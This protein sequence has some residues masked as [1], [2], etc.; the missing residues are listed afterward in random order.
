LETPPQAPSQASGEK[1]KKKSEGP[2]KPRKQSEKKTVVKK[3][4]VRKMRPDHS[5]LLNCPLCAESAFSHAE[6]LS[7]P[8]KGKYH[9][10]P[11]LGASNADHFFV[12][13]SPMPLNGPINSGNHSY[14]D[15]HEERLASGII[16]R[17]RLK[18][19]GA[20]TY[21]GCGTYAVR[22]GKA[23]P[24]A[25]V[26]GQCK[27]I[28][29]AEIL[30]KAKPNHAI[31]IFALG[32]EVLNALGIKVKKLKDVQ[33]KFMEI[34]IGERQAFVFSSF[35]IAQLVAKSG[36]IELLEQHAE[37]F[38]RAM[39]ND[40]EKGV[41]PTAG[42]ALPISQLATKYRIPK[43]LAEAVEII[44]EAIEYRTEDG[45]AP[46][47][48]LDTE[49]NTLHPH[50]AKLK[51][52][53]VVFSW[54]KG[55]AASIPVEHAESPWTL[56]D[57]FPYLNELLSCNKPKIL[58]HAKFDLRVLT[59][60]GFTV[61]NLYWD[62]LIGEHL[63]AEDKTGYYGL[64]A[65]TTTYLPKYAGY[66]DELK[67]I[68][69]AHKLI[70]DDAPDKDNGYAHIPLKDLNLYGACDAD[71]TRQLAFLQV[72][73]MVEEN[74][75]LDATC[76]QYRNH[77]AESIRA[78]YARG[79]RYAHPLENLMSSLAMPLTQVLARME[80]HGF[81]VDR[82]HAKTLA[83]DMDVGIA[84]T[85]NRLLKMVPEHIFEDFNF[86]SGPQLRQLLFTIGYKHP[87]S[88]ELVKYDYLPE[89]QLE[90][91]EGGDV[92]VNAK[93]LKMLRSQGCPFAAALLDYRALFKART[94]FIENI[95]NLSEEDGRMH[96]TF[97]ITGTATGR[98]SSSHENMQ[99][100]PYKIEA[101]GKEYH[102]KKMFVPTSPGMVICN[103]DAKAAEVR[104]YAAY[105]G[106]AN[107]IKALKG[108]MDPHSFF[109]SVVYNRESI[110]QNMPEELH[111]DT[112]ATIGID[113]V[114][115]W[116]YED[117]QNRKSFK[118]TDPTYAKKLDALRTSIKKVVFGI[119]YGA[120][121]AKISSLVGIPDEQAQAIIQVLF[122][123]F[124]TIPKY[125]D[126]VKQQ[127]N[128]IGVLETL[129][130]RRRHF[131]LKGV[132]GKL[133]A[134]AER[135]GVNFKIQS[136][137]SDIVLDTLCAID[138][139]I[140]ALGGQLLI[141]VHDSLVFQIPKENL[142]KVPDLVQRYCVDRVAEKYPWLPVPF[143]WD[144]SAGP[145]YGE[146]SDIEAEAPVEGEDLEDLETRNALEAL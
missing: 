24:G 43:T 110:L 117:F 89:E 133:R 100:I 82:E 7:C 129:T 79:S 18:V 137:S 123:M 98:L 139:P 1:K 138:A 17:A 61:S 67:V 144:V 118:E 83:K 125:I 47:I 84:Q 2:K 63:L 136:S 91:T 21:N 96:T 126:N 41:S 106:D 80:S 130:G 27:S 22:C 107:L 48:S 105:S 77:S 35:S 95:L 52:L 38:F 9:Y 32:V 8:A 75:E 128:K 66:E 13:A 121:P 50:K 141:T 10:A 51:L 134:R 33:G 69:N 45:V 58:H 112:L 72:K 57:I 104:L 90:H 124:P 103:A 53:T 31:Y 94:T 120:S 88:G 20:A 119:L 54:K 71:V 146:Q 23:D 56:E 140:R 116:S 74:K 25:D 70:T 92:S 145:S 102:I 36:F 68:D 62:T 73:R 26:I 15:S 81:Q 127:V 115:A 5:P 143:Q 14:W 46:P 6:C 42:M 93:F 97:N 87:E 55:V 131:N 114:H 19:V 101:E 28:L 122:R 65:L 49:T 11:L 39:V 60:K 113:S 99:N 78:I 4:T 135:Q 108:G 37:T 59:A 34:Q 29:T 40:I 16:M 64:K 132:Y 142:H 44:K 76:A 111:E 12:T 3:P 85:R 30:E 109:A 86:N